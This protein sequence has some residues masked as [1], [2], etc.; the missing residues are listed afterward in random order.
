M[1]VCGAV[2]GCLCGWVGG[3]ECVL[4]SRSARQQPLG[5]P[6][7]QGFVGWSTVGR[8]GPSHMDCSMPAAPVPTGQEPE[9]SSKSCVPVP[10]C[11]QGAAG[12]EQAIRLRT[13]RPTAGRRTPAAC[14]GS[15]PSLFLVL[16]LSLTLGP[17]SRSIVRSLS[18][19]LYLSPSRVPVPACR[20]GG[21]R[22][23]DATLKSRETSELQL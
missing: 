1:G 17:N 14:G 10:A 8:P 7:G 2:C 20:P 6:D 21:G 12:M 15:H 22:P 16:P 5:M 19:P 9:H 18:L 3:C 11:R 23:V 13:G 4:V